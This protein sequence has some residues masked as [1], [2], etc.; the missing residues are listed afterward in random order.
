MFDVMSLPL[1]W[2]VE[3]NY[4]EAK[5]FCS[6]KGPTYRLPTE[7]EH[8]RIRD[9]PVS[10]VQLVLVH[11]CVTLSCYSV[12]VL[13]LQ[14]PSSDASC[15]PAFQPDFKANVNLRYGS[16]SVSVCNIVL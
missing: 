5:A 9:H 10:C 2:P 15:D 13:S 4:H 12:V 11:C 7:A 16:S 14:P 1:D 6:W 8:H 3:V